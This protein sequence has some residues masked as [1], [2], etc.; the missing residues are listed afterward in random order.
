MFM[1]AMG[2]Y[3]LE[4]RYLNNRHVLPVKQ[5]DIAYQDLPEVKETLLEGAR[6]FFSY[7]KYTAGVKPNKE[8]K[9]GIAAF[10]NQA[11]ETYMFGNRAAH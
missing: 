1:A 6:I 9:K 8:L 7:L 3:L 10:E 4:E 11:L 5:P 2:K